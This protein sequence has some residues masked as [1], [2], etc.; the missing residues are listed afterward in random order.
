MK[1]T[2]CKT[3]LKEKIAYVKGKPYCQECSKQTSSREEKCKKCG[4]IFT[5][6]TQQSRTCKECQGTFMNQL[7]KKYQKREEYKKYKTCK[8]CKREYGVDGKTDNGKCPICSY[9]K[10]ILINVAIS[11]FIMSIFVVGI[12]FILIY[13]Q[14]PSGTLSGLDYMNI[15]FGE[16][17]NETMKDNFIEVLEDLNPLYLEK[18]KNITL[19]LNV[20]EYTDCGD[21]ETIFGGCNLGNGKSIIVKHDFHEATLRDTI[22]HEL[23]H[24]Y[25]NNDWGDLINHKIIYD[26][27]KKHVCFSRRVQWN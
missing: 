14:T 9:K 23:L 8:V 11:N 16:G 18:N 3:T 2:N 10:R 7:H 12:I 5:P 22:C 21:K 20:S 26:M 1:C 25:F 24:S 13:P 19:T 4:K 17:I 27:A 15:T 6:L